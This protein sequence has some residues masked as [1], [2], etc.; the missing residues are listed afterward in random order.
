MENEGTWTIGSI[1]KQIRKEQQINGSQLCYGICSPATL[2]RI[3]MDEREMN[4]T[5]AM[6][7]FGR[8]GYHPDKFE[9]YG[10]NEEY[11]QYEQRV[12]IQKLKKEKQYQQMELELKEYIKSWKCDIDADVIQQQFVYSMQGFLCL[13]KEEHQHGIELLIQATECTIPEWNGNWIQNAI[14]SETELDI[15]GLLADGFEING[16]KQKAYEIR[17]NIYTYLEQRSSNKKQMIEMYTNIICKLVPVML[18]EKNMWQGLA[19]CESGLLVLSE[20]GRMYSWPDL[21]Y[22]KG[23]CLQNL[24]LIGE[25]TKSPMT[26]AYIRA[27]YIYRLFGNYKK[28]EEVKAYL[29]KEASGWEYIRLEK[30]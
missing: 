15:M 25:E 4:F 29:D 30:L 12:S 20:G 22:W 16:E 23:R 5:F 2:S 8:L 26:D 11:T 17:K 13:Q 27:F 9:L 24:Y 3:E 6:I 7:L 18:E 1:V 21:L 19:L 28:A 10:S 14:V